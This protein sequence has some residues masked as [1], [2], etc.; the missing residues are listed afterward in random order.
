[1]LCCVGH[2]S[3]DLEMCVVN[4]LHVAKT[5]APRVAV[6]KP[7]REVQVCESIVEEKRQRIDTSVDSEI[8]KWLTKWLSHTKMESIPS[9]AKQREPDEAESAP[10]SAH[11]AVRRNSHIRL[12]L[13]LRTTHMPQSLS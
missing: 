11:E 13:A 9:R 6:Q 10:E 3:A 1:M 8:T 4:V 7:D 5:V 2:S 12:V